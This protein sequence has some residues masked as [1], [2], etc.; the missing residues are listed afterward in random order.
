MNLQI[1]FSLMTGLAM[2]V[3]FM[4]IPPVLGTLMGLYDVSYVGISVL[5]SALLW[6]HALMQIPAGLVADRLGIG[7]T[8]VAGMG[9]LAAGNMFPAV[10]PI[11]SI[12]VIGRVIT[13]LG[14]GL[15][16]GHLKFITQ[17]PR[18]ESECTTPSLPAYFPSGRP[19]PT[20]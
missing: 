6:S 9:F 15:I 16:R 19:L 5:L 1:L 7:R 8:L 20:S 2:G 3:T 13:G 18:E 12:A 11:L 4:N 10:A 14:T 17:T